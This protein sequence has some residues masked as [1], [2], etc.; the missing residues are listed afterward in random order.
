MHTARR[1]VDTGSVTCLLICLFQLSTQDKD[2]TSV[3][4]ITDGHVCIDA[5]FTKTA[6]EAG[7]AGMSYVF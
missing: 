1:V 5:E 3:K 6:L 2:G 7:L 4:L